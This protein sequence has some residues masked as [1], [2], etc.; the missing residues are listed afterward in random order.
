MGKRTLHR[1]SAAHLKR[2]PDGW[3]NDGGGLHLVVKGEGRSWAMRYTRNHKTTDMGLGSLADLPL[4]EARRVATEARRQLTLGQDPLALRR[5]ALASAATAQTFRQCAEAYIAAHEA[6]WRYERH[7]EQW[8]S[9]LERHVYPRIGDL[10]V[11]AVDT[12]LVLKVLEPIWYET[13]A[14]AS[15]IRSRIEAVL[16]WATIRRYRTGDNPARWANHLEH[17]LPGTGK[18]RRVRHHPSLPYA[19]TAAFMTELRKQAGVAP[20]AMELLILT[21]V[22]SGEVLGTRWDEIDLA[23]RLWTIPED[24]MKAARPHRVPLSDQAMMLLAEMRKLRH[25]DDGGHVFQGRRMGQPLAPMNLR[26]L[27]VRM[28]RTDITTH[29]FRSTFRDWAAEQTTFPREV[30]EQALAHA[31]G[32][33][34]EMS[35]RRT[36]LL[37]KRKRLMAA[38]SDYCSTTAAT[39]AAVVPLRRA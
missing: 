22:R 26:N 20:R 32:N 9:S 35:Y 34:T 13:P 31:I 6:S 19:E 25:A 8:V 14:S 33:P 30:C 10:P 37:N 39:S 28:E 3:H 18:L 5:Q 27:L 38:W 11:G 12:G 29:G 4:A 7:K 1:L 23:E 2:K 16:G 15:C 17:A 24:R 21:A 36:D